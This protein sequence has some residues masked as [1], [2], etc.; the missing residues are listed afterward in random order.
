MT[1]DERAAVWLHLGATGTANGGVRMTLQMLRDELAAQGL[2]VVT[3]A[4]MRVLDAMGE[5][6]IEMLK[7]VRDGWSCAPTMFHPPCLAELARREGKR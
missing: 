5:L 4:E 7:A 1:S 6:D 3:D 2:H